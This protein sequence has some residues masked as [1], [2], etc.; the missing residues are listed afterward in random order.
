MLTMTATKWT[1]KAWQV[2]GQDHI[3]YDSVTVDAASRKEAKRIAA[4]HFGFKP[5]D[6][7]F[8][9]SRFELEAY[10]AED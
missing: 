9:H 4:R 3:P 10:R 8:K 6:W 2:D 5:H 1:V 7:C